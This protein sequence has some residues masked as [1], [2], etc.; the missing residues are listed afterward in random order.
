MTG[1]TIRA[2][3]G[4]LVLALA[5][6][7]SVTTMAPPPAKPASAP[8]AE[9]SGARALRTIEVLAMKPHPTGTAAAAEVRE[10]LARQ[11]AGLGFDVEVQDA[12]GLT[13][14]FA[15]RW[16]APVLA[17]RVHNV[18]AR[19]RGIGQ[20]PAVLLMAHYDS[21]E[22]AP[23]ASDDGYGCATLLETA[24]ALAAS[25]PP[26]HDVV[27]LLTEGEEQGSLGARAFF[28]QSPIAKQIALALN[29]DMR[30][31]R[32]AVQ[33]FQTSDHAAGLIDVLANA[34]PYVAAYSLSQEVYRRMPNDSDLTP[35]LQAGFPGMNFGAI[36]GFERYHQPTDT[37]GNADAATVQHMGSYA[38]ALTRAFAAREDIVPVARGDD[39]YFTAGPLFVRY[40]AHAGAALTGLAVASIA[41]AL[42]VG[43]RAR[44]LRAGSIL[45]GTG[46]ALL[47]TLLA[48]VAARGAWWAAERAHA[49]ALGMQEVRSTPRTAFLAAMVLLG[50][51]VAAAVATWAMSRWR[52]SDLSAGA[53]V[54]WAAL[55]VTLTWV[56]PDAS[57]LYV[58]PLLAAGAAWCV[59]IARPALDDAHSMSIALHLVAPVLAILLLVPLALLFGIAFG[60]PAAPA[61]AAIGALTTTT[62]MPLLAVAPS[63]RRGVAAAV[64]GTGAC[65]CV[66]FAAASAPFDAGSPRPDS[67]VY[68]IDADQRAWWLSFDETPDEWTARIM[69][70]ASRAPLPALFPR[71]GLSAWQK[72]A[73]R[74]A[75]QRPAV[76]IVS[77]TRNGTQRTL[78]L[79]LT[80]P[81]DSEIA[82]LDVPPEAQVVSASVQGIPF[83]N[84]PQD[85]WLELAFFGP[86]AEGLDLTIVAEAGRRIALTTVAQTRGLPQ[87]LA[88]SLSPRPPDRM[89]AVVQGDALRASDMTLVAASFDL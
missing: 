2:L 7:L 74:L 86:P 78:R 16:G 52:A 69:S 61:L 12:I 32:G 62:A 88:A 22:L 28:E 40:P 75:L 18:V 27:V 42:G 4:A 76:E 13:D 37:A 24:R 36:D 26:L 29:F 60:P 21:R 67:L 15:R 70:G 72:P 81:P 10:Y 9:F 55:V 77:D 54:L 39:V 80:L 20:G 46:M 68:A 30:G 50:A 33:M 65:A 53:M 79:H 44:R 73:P 48:G 43:L 14:S 63:T 23:G 51:A 38:L 89:P 11:L 58:W 6:A 56:L 66:V 59:R 8:S 64:L 83:G 71:S 31:N 57:C 45:A 87:E 34:A 1:P 17:G 85:G 82:A 35:W 25:P 5:V 3:L 84:E 47:A 19:R 41:L 49:G